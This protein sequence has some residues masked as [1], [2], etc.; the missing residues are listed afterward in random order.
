MLHRFWHF[1]P[2]CIM[3]AITFL[4]LS[5][6]IVSS[7]NNTLPPGQKPVR[8]LFLKG[9]RELPTVQRSILFS[10][11]V[12]VRTTESDTAF[13]VH[14]L[15]QLDPAKNFKK[16]VKRIEA[17]LM[18]RKQVGQN[19]IKTSQWI[20]N[21]D[22][23]IASICSM[24]GDTS[25]I[26]QEL[27]QIDLFADYRQ[28]VSMLEDFW[29]QKDLETAGYTPR[30][31]EWKDKMDEII[32][33]NDN[34]FSPGGDYYNYWADIRA[35]LTIL[36]GLDYTEELSDTS[37]WDDQLGYVRIDDL[38]KYV[39]PCLVYYMT[40]WDENPPFQVAVIANL[41]G[42]GKDFAPHKDQVPLAG[43]F[44]VKTAKKVFNEAFQQHINTTVED[45]QL[46]PKV[47]KEPRFRFVVTS[48]P[49][50]DS[51]YLVGISVVFP[52]TEF[53]ADSLKMA[54]VISTIVIYRNPKS[55]T[56]SIVLDSSITESFETTINDDVK[57]HQYWS[58]LLPYGDYQISLSLSSV[59]GTILGVK[60]YGF[61][62]PPAFPSKRT[63][64]VLL[65]RG[66]AEAAPTGIP[67]NGE[68]LR[69]VAY[70]VFNEA[71]MLHLYVESNLKENSFKRD[72]RGLYEY[73]TRATFL[74][75]LEAN[76]R[77]SQ[78]TL[79]PVEISKDQTPGAPYRKR[80][81][82]AKLSE[83]ESLVAPSSGVSDSLLIFRGWTE[84]PKGLRK[85]SYILQIRFEDQHSDAVSHSGAIVIIK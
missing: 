25:A 40:W 50:R 36:N 29:K 51:V 60:R 78:V 77:K 3:G 74:G 4:C 6:G 33:Y 2:L 85:G 39:P 17:Y 61:Q 48:F 69:G 75:P 9:V 59:D 72:N 7:Y 19:P 18:E 49:E 32:A 65:T 42:V 62:I 34:H 71:D 21:V 8:D 43:Q 55:P 26:Y 82:P 79:G 66:K 41:D 73:I 47:K 46:F 84:I 52:A 27:S 38:R 37:C 1:L 23:V 76:E 11:Y 57:L 31:F 56:Y 64:D 63:S 30:R 80:G 54:S 10:W 20:D 5:C 35:R 15:N 13:I 24:E 70:N 12:V 83:N 22:S 67:R 44:K 81:F 68:L 45:V 28:A 53:S 14:Q 16:A 58:Q